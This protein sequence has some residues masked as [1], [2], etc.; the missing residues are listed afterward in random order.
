MKIKEPCLESNTTR[1]KRTTRKQTKK[2]SIKTAKKTFLKHRFVS[3]DS[4]Y[5]KLSLDEA[6]N[7]KVTQL[8]KLFDSY[9]LD[10]D[11]FV[12]LSEMKTA[13][14]DKMNLECVKELFKEYDK[15]GDGQLSLDEYMT[16]F[17]P[18]SV[19]PHRSP[20]FIE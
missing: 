2:I 17:L 10:K 1:K 11:G 7:E 13:L 16:M 15:D 4:C 6:Y 18:K 20:Y 9:D 8:K 19:L 5:N 14:R 12:S 3:L